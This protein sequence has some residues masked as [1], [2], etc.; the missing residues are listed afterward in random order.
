MDRR[1]LFWFIL[2]IFVIFSII[3]EVHAKDPKEYPNKAITVLIGFSP[4]GSTDITMRVISDLASKIL[5]QP[6]VSESKVGASGK[7]ALG[8]I[9][10]VSPDGYTIGN[11]PV[12]VVTREP[13]LQEV[14]FDTLRDFT[15][16]MQYT[17]Y[18][19]TIS[20][21]AD[22]PWKTLKELVTAMKENPAKFTVGNSGV[23]SAGDIAWRIIGK[24][25]GINIRQIPYAGGGAQ[26]ILALLGG[27]LQAVACGGEA[28]PHVRTGQLRLLANLGEERLS[29]FPEI[30]TLREVG[31]PFAN[32]SGV[33]ITGPKGLPQ[34]ILKKLENAFTEASKEQRFQETLQKFDLPY[35]YKT[36]EQLQKEIPVLYSHWGNL[37]KELGITGK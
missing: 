8:A 25:A 1:F 21:R 10:K 18:P 5:G 35:V 33:A 7:V 26:A 24:Q 13:H 16:I 17:E 37:F 19:F 14:P 34:P 31:Y 11:M 9:A 20:V 22:S 4:G 29:Y 3:S 2:A 32:V 36:S 27:H 15:P 28:N 30:P 12:A 6:L 23:N